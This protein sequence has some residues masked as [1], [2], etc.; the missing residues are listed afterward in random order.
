MDKQFTLKIYNLA[1]DYLKT[2]N[3]DLV[4][5]EVSFTDKL[6]G[7]MGQCQVDLNLPIDDFDEG[8]S[9]AHMNVVRIY[10]SDNGH[11]AP[12]L[13]YTGF[14]SQY[15]PYI[16]GGTQA[17]RLTLL[18]LVS[19]L[20][21]GYYKSGSSYAF[22]KT[23]D[24]ANIIKDIIDGFNAVYTGNWIDYDGGHV[25]DVGVTI[26]YDIDRAK[27][28][29]VLKNVALFA[30]DDWWWHIGPDGQVYLQ[31]RPNTAT[32]LLT[33]G[34]NVDDLQITKNSEKVV[35]RFRLS[36]GAPITVSVYE[37]LASQAVYGLR[38]KL[39]TDVATKNSTTADQ[40][41]NKLIADFKDAKIE[42]TLRVNTKY[43]IESI[44][45]GDTITVRNVKAGSGV[46]P[47][48]LLVTAINYNPNSV[49][50][51]LENQVPSLADTFVQAVE[52]IQ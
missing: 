6:F 4:M 33:I 19:L 39:E 15:I 52:D 11:A 12:R 31:D 37:D 25:D 45:P 27:W 30:S 49:T 5:N 29:D 9:I 38:E 32:H 8:Q 3:P 17:V 20:S 44:R 13:I 1:G 50:L 21:L 18:G 24:P 34:Q 22:N 40:K 36:W 47:A 42:A 10:E 23:D 43:D 26:N 46:L 2:L 51:T 41:G 35:N 48:N 16:S 14:I 7:G 28:L